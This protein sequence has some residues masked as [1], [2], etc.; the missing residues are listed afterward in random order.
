[1]SAFSSKGVPFRTGSGGGVRDEALDVGVKV[2]FLTGG[3]VR[4][5][6]LGGLTGRGGR[7][8]VDDISARL[9][10]LSLELR[11]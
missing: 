7:E 1:M 3:T 10:S 9:I 11:L 2:E 8:G 5:G 6:G 4:I